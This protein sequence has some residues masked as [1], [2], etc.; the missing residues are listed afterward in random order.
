MQSAHHPFVRSAA[1]VE[2]VLEYLAFKKQYENA[3]PRDEIPDFQERIPPEVALELYVDFIL[4]NQRQSI[5]H[6]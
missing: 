1:V 4:L 5:D 6:I 2:K 3:G